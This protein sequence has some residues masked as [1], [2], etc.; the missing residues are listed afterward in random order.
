MSL[1][2]KWT[3]QLTLLADWVNRFNNTNPVWEPPNKA[4]TKKP[5][6][7]L[8]SSSCKRDWRSKRRSTRP[9]LLFIKQN[10]R[11]KKKFQLNRLG[12][13]RQIAWKKNFKWWE[14][15]KQ[16]AIELWKHSR[17]RLR[18]PN[19]LWLQMKRR[20]LL[21][22]MMEWREIMPAWRQ[23]WSRHKSS[24]MTD[25]RQK[26]ERM[27]LMHSTKLLKKERKNTMIRKKSSMLPRRKLKTSK[28]KPRNWLKR[29]ISRQTQDLENWP[30]R[31]V[32][33]PRPEWMSSKRLMKNCLHRRKPEMKPWHSKTR[34]TRNTPGWI[35]SRQLSTACMTEEV[36]WSLK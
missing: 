30:K 35:N 13:R 14:I 7:K 33:L 29:L 22:S 28:K 15:L 21:L 3:T 12:N 16:P 32:I 11:S 1:K 36:D 8:K 5:L 19:S 31:D 25:T 24:S 34:S 18:K 4:V 20:R 17:L 2:H 27:N 26:Q 9:I 23:M 6:S 10:S